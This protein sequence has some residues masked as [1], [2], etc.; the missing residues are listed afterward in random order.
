MSTLIHPEVATLGTTHPAAKAH[1][2]RFTND[3]S[4]QLARALDRRY[5]VRRF[6]NERLQETELEALLEAVRHSPSAYGLQPY[7]VVVVES[8]DVRK[9]LLAHSYAQQK[10]VECSHLLV[11]A[12]CQDMTGELVDR[13][14]AVSSSLTGEPASGLDAYADGVR[15]ALASQSREERAESAHRQA[16]IALGTLVT[17]A[18][19]LGVDC[20]PMSG[21]DAAGYDAVLGLG[22]Q[23]LTASVICAL[24][25]RHP[26]DAAATRPRVRTPRDEFVLVY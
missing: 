10:V 19:L 5:A 16:F 11:L 1:P 23:G 24:G 22:E 15:S 7:K 20:C 12:A 17:S 6:S 8:R 26:Q 25:R 9:R 3:A 14:V 4:H 21:F 13:Y 18:A 2:K